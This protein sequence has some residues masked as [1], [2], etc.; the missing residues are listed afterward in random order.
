MQ[1]MAMNK[2]LCLSSHPDDIEYGT[3]GT[4]LKYDKT[5]FDIFVFSDGGDFDLSTGI[6][7][8]KECQNIWDSISNVNGNFANKLFVKDMSEDEWVSLIEKKY[9]ID[10]YDCIFTITK[11]DSH[12]EHRMINHIAFALT[13]TSKCG[14][15]TY[16]TPSTL[17]N[18]V[19]NIY[20]SIDDVIEKKVKLLENFKSQIIK[21]TAGKIYFERESILAFHKNYLASKTGIKHVEMFKVVKYF[22]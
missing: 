6:K 4:M 10:D 11:Y 5:N 7:R 9:N 8:Q 21:K 1:F 14:I 2:V 17:E 16:K 20:V 22:S 19:P 13:R 3:L 12:F 15:L 18:W